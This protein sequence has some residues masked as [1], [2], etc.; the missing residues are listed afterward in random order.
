MRDYVF[1]P[2]SLS[3][4]FG[5]LGKWAREKIG[6]KAGKIFATSIATFI[7]YL[8]I[9]IWHGANFRYIA[10]GFWNGA[11]ITSSL[12]LAGPYETLKA[13]LHINEGSKLWKFFQTARTSFIVFIG[14][15]ITKA[16]RL[17]TAVWLVLKTF[18]PMTFA[19]TDLWNGTLLGFGLGL[20]DFI[21]IGVCTLF[22]HSVEWYEE[23]KGPV[24]DALAKSR[25]LVQWV[26]MTILILL[27]VFLG[28]MRGSYIS[29]EFIY[30]AF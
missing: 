25:G 7:V 2:I 27:I 20:S 26:A 10:F 16:P 3:K 12:L 18:N 15:Y 11:I 19:I 22:M 28:I 8:I 30:K 29:S 24:I 5:K 6:G 1:Y 23:K 21:I 4:P 17:L 14:R 13:K 9:G